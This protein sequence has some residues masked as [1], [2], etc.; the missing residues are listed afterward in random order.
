MATEPAADGDRGRRVRHRDSRQRRGGH[1][2]RA[3]RGAPGRDGRGAGEDGVVRRIHRPFGGRDMGT[4]QHGAAP[5]GGRRYPRA[6][7]RLPGARDGR[8]RPGGAAA[9]AARALP[10]HARPRPGD[11]TAALRVG[12]R[13]RRLLSRGARRA[14]VRTQHRAGAARR[15][16]ARRRACQAEPALPAGSRRRR[17]HPGRLPLAEPRPPASARHPRQREGRGPGGAHP[18]ARG[19]GCSASGR[20]W[21]RGCGPGCCP[22]T[23]RCGWIP[24]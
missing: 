15:E 20:R 18:P 2:G 21:R 23:C 19:T 5:R 3:R 12:A 4:G 9:R 10:G 22:A 17:R 24:R 1:D 8:P 7:Q 11:D 6:G 14:G 16:R 13:L